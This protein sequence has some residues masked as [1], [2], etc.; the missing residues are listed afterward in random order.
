MEKKAT[1]KLNK[2]DAARRQL[3][4]ALSLWFA[5]GEPV[6]IH[7]LVGA[8]YQ[9]IHDLNHWQKG[10]P[11]IFDNPIIKANLRKDAVS[12]LK[13]NINFFKHADTN[14]ARAAKV[15]LDFDPS[16]S[17]L[18]LYGSVIGMTRLGNEL[19]DMESAF[20][21]WCAL[22]RPLWAMSWKERINDLFKIE[23]IIT[24]GALEKS[25]FLS[26]YLNSRTLRITNGLK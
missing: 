13:K 23:S 19:T 18:F 6:S 25:E 9:I 21:F 2:L 7:T 22:H 24:L 20:M 10:P 5:D 8:A 12:S 17:E 1:I 14:Q 3:D 4:T 26:C 11:L 15:V 16:L